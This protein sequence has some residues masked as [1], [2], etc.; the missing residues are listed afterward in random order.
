MLQRLQASIDSSNI[1][2]I[3]EGDSDGE[4][5]L[6]LFKRPVEKVLQELI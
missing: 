1:E 6:E 3:V 2:I 5:V 4:Q